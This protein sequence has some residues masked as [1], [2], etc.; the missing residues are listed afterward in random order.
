M[1]NESLENEGLK[2]KKKHEHADTQRPFRLTERHS[3]GRREQIENETRSNRKLSVIP[4]EKDKSL[5]FVVAVVVVVDGVEMSE[6]IFLK[7]V[8][9]YTKTHTLR[10]SLGIWAI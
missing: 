5:A 2:F 1:C 9:T 3:A 6:N 4:K 8:H 7:I 10:N